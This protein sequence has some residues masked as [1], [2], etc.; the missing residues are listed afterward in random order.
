M[1]YEYT[2]VTEDGISRICATDTEVGYA[3][4]QQGSATTETEIQTL[5]KSFLRI[6]K[7]NEFTTKT[8]NQTS[9]RTFGMMYTWLAKSSV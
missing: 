6:L 2:T 4:V 5:L 8:S 7:P 9:P 1:T 3:E